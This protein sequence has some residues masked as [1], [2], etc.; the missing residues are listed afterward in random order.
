[1]TDNNNNQFQARI[2]VDSRGKRVINPA[3]DGRNRQPLNI[4]YALPQQR[5]YATGAS[6][7]NNNMPGSSR[8][9]V[10]WMGNTQA[11][12][13]PASRPQEDSSPRVLISD[14]QQVFD[15]IPQQQH[16][17]PR[18]VLVPEASDE[19]RYHYPAH[20]FR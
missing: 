7:D 16:F 19:Q 5:F 9:S 11:Q 14:G 10:P 4:S 13:Q 3:M 20:N 17:V 15:P 1:M 6:Q 8:N 18:S 2:T 12:P